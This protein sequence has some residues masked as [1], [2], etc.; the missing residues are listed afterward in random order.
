MDNI[1]PTIDVEKLQQAAN[2]YALK[3]A[4]EVIKEYYSGYKSP[5]KE[6]IQK[7]LDEKGVSVHIELPDIIGILNQKLSHEID[8]IA[9]TALAKT[10]IPLVQNMLVREEKEV[11]FSDILRAFIRETDS[12]INDG[13]YVE[14]E[15]H[16]KYSWLSINIGN[17]DIK[18]DLTLHLDH[19]DKKTYWI[20]TLPHD[21]QPSHRYSKMTL[22]IADNTKLEMPFM[23]D[24]LSDKFVSYI[25]KLII[26]ECRITMDRNDF[27]DEM[28]N[29]D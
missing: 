27:E 26:G 13:C 7:Q 12:E 4:I 23:P 8:K 29:K 21:F 14:I 19:N 20:G 15:K 6:A 10:Y 25:A 9:N 2:E 5:Y 22:T 24:V 18:Y 11:K 3:G 17:N 16:E 28:F 1:V